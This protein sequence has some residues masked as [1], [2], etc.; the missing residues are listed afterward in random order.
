VDVLEADDPSKF[1]AASATTVLPGDD[2]VGVKDPVIRQLGGR[3]HIWLC[4]HPLG[5]PDHTDRMSTQYGSSVDGLAWDLHGMALAGTPGKWDQRGA[6]VADVVHRGGRW[7]AY[8]GGRAS[9]EENAEERT[10]IAVGDAP[11]S[12]VAEEG[13]IGAWPDG[14]GSLRYISA[15]A[16]PDGGTR[17]YYGTSRR[18]GAH[19]LRTEYVPPER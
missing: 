6:R 16:L 15:V 11:G 12:L 7:L 3:W 19:D 5:L 17:L 4:C 14:Q 9:A 1:V 2:A 18:D 10:G 13:V 8:Y